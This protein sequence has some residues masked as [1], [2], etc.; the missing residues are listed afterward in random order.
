MKK[1]KPINIT[2]YC[3]WLYGNNEETVCYLY[4]FRVKI[5]T[6]CLLGN[7]VKRKDYWYVSFCEKCAADI[8]YSFSHPS[9]IEAIDYVE[10]KFKIRTWG[11]IKEY[12]EGYID[13]N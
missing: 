10:E 13:L 9:L 6:I 11:I 5:A 2:G 12:E 1:N 4:L 3:E 8:N 7:C